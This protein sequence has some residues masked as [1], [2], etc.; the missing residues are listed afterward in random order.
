MWREGGQD[1]VGVGDAGKRGQHR[2]PTDGIIRTNAIDRQDCQGRVELTRGLE[3]VSQ[4]A[5]APPRVESANWWGLVARSKAERVRARQAN[6]SSHRPQARA[7]RRWACGWP[8][9]GQCQ[10]LSLCWG[11]AGLGQ[12]VRRLSERL[13]QWQGRRAQPA[14][15]GGEAAGSRGCPPPRPP[16]VCE[17]DTGVELNWRVGRPLQQVRVEVAIGFSRSVG[18][19]S[20]LLVCARLAWRQ[21]LCKQDL[22]GG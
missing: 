1:A 7:P 19:V 8:S 5:S 11:E 17:Q 2:L 9:G 12:A 4:R 14:R 16:Q 3:G 13:G 10:W 22:P 20:K 18:W 21:R 6:A 15:F